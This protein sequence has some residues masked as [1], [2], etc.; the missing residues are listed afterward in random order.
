MWMG[1]A[2]S[3]YV[4]AAINNKFYTNIQG[5]VNFD[6]GVSNEYQNL[7]IVEVC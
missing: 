5:Y 1:L 2:T 7:D 6:D 3:L 4:S